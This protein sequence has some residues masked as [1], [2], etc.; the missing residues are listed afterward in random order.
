[1]N[2]ANLIP[3]SERDQ[4]ERKKIAR[5][6]GILSGVKRRKNRDM[7]D[8]LKTL[9]TA[10]IRD[11]SGDMVFVSEAVAERIVLGALDGD[12]R[13]ARLLADYLYGKPGTRKEPAEEKP[14][15]VPRIEIGWA[16]SV[17]I[18]AHPAKLRE[19]LRS[20]SDEEFGKVV[21]EVEA[22]RLRRESGQA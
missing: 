17:D 20:M 10:K 18:M 11:G 16:S 3:F 7:I 2:E 13:F 4:D 9:M 19:D 6:A 12:Y 22:E 5:M 21:K 15:E 14:V 8:A 1:M